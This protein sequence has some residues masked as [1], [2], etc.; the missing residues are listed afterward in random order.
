M[1]HHQLQIWVPC[2]SGKHS[3]FFNVNVS[4]CYSNHDDGCHWKCFK[5]LALSGGF[6]TPL[7]LSP[8]THQLSNSFLT[9]VFI[10]AHFLLLNES[11]TR[12][13]SEDPDIFPFHVCLFLDKFHLYPFASHSVFS[14]CL[15][16]EGN[17]PIPPL[18]HVAGGEISKCLAS[19]ENPQPQWS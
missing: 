17:T 15:L 6:I 19:V 13:S 9:L 2:I 10:V 3:Y 18:V 8:L 11:K 7:V 14:S 1:V 4:G 12:L 5:A 16:N